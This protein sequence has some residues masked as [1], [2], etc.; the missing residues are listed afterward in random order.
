MKNIVPEMVEIGDI[1]ENYTVTGL[2]DF[3]SYDT[4]GE[5]KIDTWSLSNHT[6]PEGY[7]YHSDEELEM[8]DEIERDLKIALYPESFYT[9]NASIPVFASNLIVVAIKIN[10]PIP[11]DSCSLLLE[12]KNR[13]IIRKWFEMFFLV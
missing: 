12:R 10:D 7:E 5:Y 4:E 9:Q 8:L 6:V 13:K 1:V 2:S 11:L 3:M